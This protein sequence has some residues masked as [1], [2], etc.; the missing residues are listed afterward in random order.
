MAYSLAPNPVPVT[1]TRVPFGPDVVAKE[2][3]GDDAWTS[4]INGVAIDT[5]SS[6]ASIATDIFL[7][8]KVK[9]FL[10]KLNFSLRNFNA[11]LFYSLFFIG[12][13]SPMACTL[14][15]DCVN[16]L[17]VQPRSCIQG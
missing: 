1:F 2:A 3:V 5:S 8:L 9:L 16:R 11:H 13:V 14:F 10:F 6:T 15:N 7:F 12:Q 17:G 4:V